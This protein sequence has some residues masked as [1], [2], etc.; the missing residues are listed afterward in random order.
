V[1]NH[2]DWQEQIPFYVAQSLSAE[3]LRSFETHLA[4]CKSC[5]AEISEWRVI[6]SAVWRDT[7]EIA[8]KLPPLSQEVYNRLNYRDK[9]PVSR[10]AANPP[11]PQAAQ[12]TALPP[13]VTVLPQR[14]RVQLPI[15]MVAGLIVAVIFGGLLLSFTLRSGH[16]GSD[17]VALLDTQNALST[18]ESGGQPDISSTPTNLAIIPTE[19][20]NRVQQNLTETMGTPTNTP[21]PSATST[22]QATP[23][24]FEPTMNHEFIIGTSPVPPTPEPTL[25]ATQE[26]VAPLGGG[27]YITITPGLYS[28]G[29]AYCDIYNPTD[30][31]IELYQSANWN[32]P[33]TGVLLPG[34]AVRV[35]TMSTEGWYYIVLPNTDRGWI[36]PSMAYLRGSCY[37]AYD[38]PFATAT[39]SLDASPTFEA[40]AGYEASSGRVVVID[41]AYADLQTEPSFTSTIMGVVSRNEQFAVLGYQ[42]TGTN[43]FVNVLLADGQSA[44]IWAQI[45]IDYAASEAPPSPTPQP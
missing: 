45:V 14:R 7:D 18:E 25:P 36:A 13:N 35:V 20:P 11:R 22:M 32:A 17:E 19:D 39:Y 21:K 10:Y 6:A 33:I 23:E 12:P 28:E 1:I 30:I 40:S 31:Q 2:Q 24:T 15:T 27:P 4:S 3:Q 29:A 8:R 41:A 16:E 44:W 5:Q 26:A 34:Q 38:I 42:G 37:A 43:R 9:P